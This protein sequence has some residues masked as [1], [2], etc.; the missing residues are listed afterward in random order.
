MSYHNTSIYSVINSVGS[1]AC[2]KDYGIRRKK[3]EESE[4]AE[5]FV[6]SK[7]DAVQVCEIRSVFELPCRDCIYYQSKYCAKQGR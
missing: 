4:F 5:A 6:V 3:E 7:K 2:T 1:I